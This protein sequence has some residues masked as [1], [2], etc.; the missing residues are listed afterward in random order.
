MSG[1]LMFVLWSLLL[2]SPVLGADSSL[3][4]RGGMNEK[5]FSEAKSLKK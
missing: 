2:N 3:Y 5:C 4:G 1:L